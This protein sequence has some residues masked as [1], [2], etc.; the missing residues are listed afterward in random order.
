[1]AFRPR[2]RRLSS[3]L[4][5]AVAIMPTCEP[6]VHERHVRPEQ[7]LVGAH[8]VHD[9]LQRVRVVERRARLHVHVGNG[10]H[11]VDHDLA[12]RRVGPARVRD[13]PLDAG[14]ALVQAGVARVHVHVRRIEQEVGVQHHRQIFLAAPL[15]DVRVARVL[16]RDHRVVGIELDEL[17]VHLAE[18]AVQLLDGL[19]GIVRAGERD[20]DEP[21]GVRLDHLGH[22]VVSAARVAV[23]DRVDAGHVDARRVQDAQEA[24]GLVVHPADAP[25][26][27]VR[28]EVYDRR[29]HVRQTSAGAPRCG[30]TRPSGCL[31]S[32]R[33]GAGSTAAG[34][35]PRPG[36]ASRT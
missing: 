30:S 21:V 13:D 23:E 9:E 8:A 27:P 36:S 19:L 4:M 24:L 5:S 35:W 18:G 22:H 12:F 20:R 2:M 7:D 11:R 10:V 14:K 16:R 25:A 26:S 17:H 1:M 28:V 3:S 29:F 32:A 34:R 31:R 6:R 33:R 15:Q